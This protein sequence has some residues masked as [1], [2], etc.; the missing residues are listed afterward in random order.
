R[1]KRGFIAKWTEHKFYIHMN[2]GWGGQGNGWFFY[3]GKNEYDSTN[4]N[5]GI[6]KIIHISPNKK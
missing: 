4:G 6:T 2:W 3:N 5:M 1:V